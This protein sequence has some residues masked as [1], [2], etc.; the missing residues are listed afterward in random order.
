M[1]K[2]RTAAPSAATPERR[3]KA[4]ALRSAQV[5]KQRRDR[6]V[7][8]AGAVVGVLVLVGVVLFVTQPRGGGSSQVASRQVLPSSVA[9]LGPGTT[10]RAAVVVPDSSGIPGVVAYAVQAAGSAALA[11]VLQNDHVPGS[12]A[13]SVTPPVGGPHNAAWMN[14]G[15]YTQPVPSER[16]VHDLEHGAVWITYRPSLAAG[17]V[18][19]LRALALRQPMVA[20]A[21]G[22][23]SR[24]TDLSPWMSGALPAPIVVSAWGRQLQVGNA[25]DLRLQRF[26]EA[27]RAHRGVTPELG[28]PCGGVP[29]DVGGR[30][31]AS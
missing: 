12:V 18:S 15:V 22:A 20:D 17:Q 23:G 27:F 14:C 1:S 10:Q 9:T 16:A 19:V 8:L 7:L 24:Y 31:D 5:S 13:Y 2:R 11:G 3:A 30:P 4:A 25:A 26:I 6:L 21:S 28:S 29:V